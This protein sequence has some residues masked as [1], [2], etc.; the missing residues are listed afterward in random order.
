M[1]ELVRADVLAA[2]VMRELRHPLAKVGEPPRL[3]DVVM[4]LQFCA[5]DSAFIALERDA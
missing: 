4:V 1:Y 5:E 3:L 2:V